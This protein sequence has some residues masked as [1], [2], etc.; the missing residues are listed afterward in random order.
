MPEVTSMVAEETIIRWKKLRE[1]FG[2]IMDEH[3]LGK[4][5]ES[6]SFRMRNRILRVRRARPEAAE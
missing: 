3:T 4:S 6:G 5:S 1:F 2:D